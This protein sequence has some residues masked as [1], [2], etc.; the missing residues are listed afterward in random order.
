MTHFPAGL[1]KCDIF[2]MLTNLFF[3]FVFFLFS[4]TSHVKK[5]MFYSNGFWC[6]RCLCCWLLTSSLRFF[7]SFDRCDSHEILEIE[8]RNKVS[9]G[10]FWFL[11]I[12]LLRT[13]EGKASCDLKMFS[14]SKHTFHTLQKTVLSII[15]LFIFLP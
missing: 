5:G 6:P 7:F 12:E 1:C 4:T 3:F 9:S 2:K 14:F 13:N 15:Y 11:P 8:I 10:S